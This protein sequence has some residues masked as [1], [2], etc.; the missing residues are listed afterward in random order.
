MK[1]NEKDREREKQRGG[2]ERREE[3]V[4]EASSGIGREMVERRHKEKEKL[5]RREAHSGNFFSSKFQPKEAVHMGSPFS[6]PEA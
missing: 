3:E 5:W 6:P 2:R 4:K 1:R